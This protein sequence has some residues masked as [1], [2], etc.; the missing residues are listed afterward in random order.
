VTYWS[1][2]VAT[3]R[4]TVP[5]VAYTVAYNAQAADAVTLDKKRTAAQAFMAALDTAD[6]VARYKRNVTP[7]RAWLNSVV[8]DATL[9]AALASL[10]SLVAGL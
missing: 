1:N 9:A 10:T 8:D 7:A 2:Q 6:K 5:A 3:G 4:I